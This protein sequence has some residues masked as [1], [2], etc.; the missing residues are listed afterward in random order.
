MKPSVRKWQDLTEPYRAESW[1][2]CARLAR[3]LVDREPYDLSTRALLASVLLRGDQR[4]L[5]LMQYERLLPLAVGQGDLL[6]AIGTQRRLDDLQS[7]ASRHPE[8]Y[9]AMQDWF[10]YVG[11][12]ALG[13]SGSRAENDPAQAPAVALLHLPPESFTLIA[14]RVS[15]FPLELGPQIHHAP[16]GLLWVVYFGRLEWAIVDAHDQSRVDHTAEEGDVIQMPPGSPTERWLEVTAVTPVEVMQFDPN[17]ADV[18]DAPRVAP[19][20]GKP[21][22]VAR[23]FEGLAESSSPREEPGAGEPGPTEA[24]RLEPAGHEEDA[25]RVAE[26]SGTPTG[27]PVASAE[28]SSGAAPT[29]AA[30]SAAGISDTARRMPVRPKLPRPDPFAEPTVAVGGARDRRRSTRMAVM[31]ET[32]VAL[33][34]EAGTRTAPLGGI[35]ANVSYT[36]VGLRFPVAQMRHAAGVEKD[37]IVLIQIALNGLDEPIAVQGRIV[38]LDLT[39]VPDDGGVEFGR[40]GLEFV[41]T[42]PEVRSRLIHVLDQAARQGTTFGG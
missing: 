26:G 29:A 2:E 8:R 11:E 40:I 3:A 30:G 12:P 20:V 25:S 7:A 21:S 28:I 5:A 14:E 35:V 17:V 23:S 18:L 42:P 10:R 34:G 31:L 37:A 41:A 22:T 9:R 38:W 24:S 33:L 13:E 1:H 27:G 6:R 15:V 36:G 39:P 4:A 32:K 16:E 19:P